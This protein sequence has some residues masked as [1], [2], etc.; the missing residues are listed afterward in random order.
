MEEV[1][2][3]EMVAAIRCQIERVRELCLSEEVT[4][5]IKVHEMRKAFKRLNALLKMFPE[6]LQIV[7]DSFRKPMRG[8]ARRLTLGRESTVNLQLFERID[9]EKGGLDDTQNSLL[10]GKL[11]QTKEESLLELV[12]EEKI[13]VDVLQ[14]MNLGNDNLLPL[15]VSTEYFVH[16]FDKIQAAFLRSKDLFRVI[17]A[18]Y[19]AELYHELRKQ[20]KTL[21]YQSEVEAPGQTEVPGTILEKLHNIADQQGDD[22]DWYV[23]LNEISR[24]KYGLTTDA[25]MQLKEQVAQIQEANLELLN[26]NL[27]DFFTLSEL[28]YLE[29]LRQL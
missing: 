11:N 24:Q 6:E 23:F 14:L 2:K 18:R 13:L 22:H 16:V 20:M 3:K 12:D 19:D 9:F 26:Q 4:V 15:L 27:S 8:I 25:M 7:V 21:W 5:E 29:L 28:Q 17:A 1:H 10:R